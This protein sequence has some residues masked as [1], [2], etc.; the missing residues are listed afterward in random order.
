M[1]IRA[2]FNFVHVVSVGTVLQPCV[3]LLRDITPMRK[4]YNVTP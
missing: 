1:L 3:Y 2:T 4:R